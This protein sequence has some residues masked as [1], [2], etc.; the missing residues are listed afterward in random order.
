MPAIIVIPGLDPGIHAILHGVLRRMNTRGPT[1]TIRRVG[2]TW[3]PGS[4]PG[5]TAIF[6]FAPITGGTP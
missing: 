1:A 2:T 3:M 6:V 4:S 5:M